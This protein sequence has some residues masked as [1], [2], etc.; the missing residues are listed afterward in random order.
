MLPSY[1]TLLTVLRADQGIPHPLSELTTCRGMGGRSRVEPHCSPGWGGT[2]HSPLPSLPF[3]HG[4]V[5]Y[6]PWDTVG[7]LSPLLHG[8]S[9]T[10]LIYR[11]GAFDT[12]SVKVESVQLPIKATGQRLSRNMSPTR[13]HERLL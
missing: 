13:V 12:A 9:S 6:S 3:S 2:V 10:E 4:E 1:S 7:Y 5:Y 11:N 8:W